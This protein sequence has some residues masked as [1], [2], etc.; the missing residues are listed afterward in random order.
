MLD[1]AVVLFALYAFVFVPLGRKTGYEHARAIFSTQAARDAGRD[2]WRAVERLKHALLD[3]HS[4]GPEPS[5]SAVPDAARTPAPSAVDAG[6]DVSVVL[7][8]GS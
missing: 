7:A 2:M 8:H 4:L 3:G 1:A 6:A 5:G